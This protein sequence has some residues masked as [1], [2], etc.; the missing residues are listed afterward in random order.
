MEKYHNKDKA[1]EFYLKIIDLVFRDQIDLALNQLNEYRLAYPEVIGMGVPDNSIIPT[2]VNRFKQI[3]NTEY[4]INSLPIDEYK[5]KRVLSIIAVDYLQSSFVSNTHDLFIHEFL[6]VYNILECKPLIDFINDNPTGLFS[7][8]EI[9]DEN[10]LAEMFF[11]SIINNS[12]NLVFIKENIE[13]FLDH[14]RDGKQYYL[15][16]E[17][18]PGDNRCDL[19]KGQRILR[20]PFSRLKELPELPMYPGCLCWYTFYTTDDD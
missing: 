7:H 11:H 1:F 16:I 19:C 18:S 9:D 14:K 3:L 5:K 2:D 8:C 10:E 12:Y 13:F 20:Y 4:L 6:K 15:G 17:V